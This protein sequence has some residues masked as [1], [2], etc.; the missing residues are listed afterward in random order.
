MMYCVALFREDLLVDYLNP[1]LAIVCYWLLPV[2]GLMFFRHF[3]D[4]K[5]DTLYLVFVLTLPLQNARRYIIP[6][7]IKAQH[8]SW[9]HDDLL[10][11]SFWDKL[12]MIWFF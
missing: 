5:Y 2:F 6:E 8:I 3:I 4:I 12:E 1:G 7:I 11:F 10:V 9:H